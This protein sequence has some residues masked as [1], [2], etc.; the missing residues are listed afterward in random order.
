MML[1]LVLYCYFKGV[2]FSRKISAACVDDVGCRVIRGGAAPS[3]QAVAQFIRR[4]RA[5]LKKLFVQVLSLLA[6]E[7]A[8]QGHC[9]AVDGSPVSGNTSRFANVTGDQLAERIAAL[10]AATGGGRGVAGRRR[11]HRA[12]AVVAGRR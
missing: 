3:Q 1:A 6:A 2:R 8:V 7:G 4:H 10:E 12:A 11:R 5:A 9:A